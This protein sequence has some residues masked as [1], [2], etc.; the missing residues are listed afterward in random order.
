MSRRRCRPACG[1]PRLRPSRCDTCNQVL[2]KGR[3]SL[4]PVRKSGAITENRSRYC[5]AC[6]VARMLRSL[7]DPLAS[8]PVT[9]SV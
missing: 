9:H 8:V 7:A 6:I 3:C 1:R 4:Q 2:P 5:K